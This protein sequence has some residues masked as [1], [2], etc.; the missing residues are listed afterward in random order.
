MLISMK[1]SCKFLDFPPRSIQNGFVHRFH[2]HFTALLIAW[3]G[4]EE[5][6][7]IRKKFRTARVNVWRGQRAAKCGKSKL[8]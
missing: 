4:G 1:K 2:S 5:E 6:G 7:E 3:A 8:N